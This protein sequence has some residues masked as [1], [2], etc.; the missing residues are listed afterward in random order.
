MFLELLLG[1]GRVI[2]DLDVPR[3][4]LGCFGDAHDG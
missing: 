4:R 2:V 1:V 3:D